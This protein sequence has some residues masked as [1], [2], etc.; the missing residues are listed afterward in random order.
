MIIQKAN[1]LCSRRLRNCVALI[2][3]KVSSKG[4]NEDAYRPISQR[5]S[6]N[7][8]GKGS[9]RALKIAGTSAI[10]FAAMSYSARK[11]RERK[12]LELEY[13]T[14]ATPDVMESRNFQ[15][16][17]SLVQ[18][19]GLMG[20]FGAKSV[21]DELDCIRK[22]H[23]EHGFKG[24]LVLRDLTEPLFTSQHNKKGETGII[25][26]M[27]NLLVDPMKLARREC[28]YLYYEITGAG[29]IRQQI[30]CRGTTLAI[31]VLTCLQFWMVHDNELDCRIH[32]G[33]RN[34]ADRILEDVLPLLSPEADKRATVEV[35][36]H[37][38]GGA[39]ACIVAAKLRK[40]GYN[41]VRLTTVG[42]PRFCATSNSA[43]AIRSLLPKDNLRIENDTDPVVF[44]PTFG[45]H[46]GNKLWLLQQSNA[47]AFIADDGS[48]TWVDSFLVNFLAFETFRSMG[49][50]HRV[51]N[52]SSFLKRMWGVETIPTRLERKAP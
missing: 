9:T 22:W 1:S 44:L 5:Q 19:T 48:S 13:V 38:L 37:S 43:S 46:V 41:V 35:S 34:Q 26:D 33:F 29:E 12:L 8:E 6:Y 20:I 30:F 50:S 42:S 40:R 52:Y 17:I 25:D 51:P 23:H 15:D 28:Y 7:Y 36:G 14:P 27:E 2:K 47:V 4:G 21:K 24:G 45:H 10:V 18:R 11:Y 32:L 3:R 31:D 49:Q 16:L 39:V